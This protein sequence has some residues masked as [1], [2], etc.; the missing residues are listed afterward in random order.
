[1]DPF[2]LNGR[3]LDTDLLIFRSL[4]AIDSNTNLP[5]SSTYILG[6]DGLGGLNWQDIFT[7]ISSYSGLIGAPIPYLPSTIYSFS[8]QL[9]TLSTI[10]GNTF[11]TLSTQDAYQFSTLS[12]MIGRGGIPGSITSQELQSTVSDIYSTT[13][14][15]SS[16]NLISTVDG[17]I[18]GNLSFGALIIS[19]T[20]GLGTI[21]Y[22]STLSLG[23]TVSRLYTYIDSNITNLATTPGYVS[24]TQLFSTVANLGFASYISSTQLRSTV[25]SIYLT[26]G[27]QILSTIDHLGSK[28][29]ISSSQLLST[30]GGIYSNLTRN[31]NVDRA[32][33]L[34]VYNS[35]VT[36]SS[37]QNLAFLSSFYFSTM[38]YSGSNGDIIGNN[39]TNTADIVFT[40]AELNL[41][42]HSNFIVPSSKIIVDAYPLFT[43]K[44]VNMLTSPNATQIYPLSTL[45]SYGNNFVSTTDSTYITNTSY[46][47]GNQFTSGISNVFQSPVRVSFSGRNIG[48]TENQTGYYVDQYK[49][50]HILPSSLTSNLT[51]GI[52]DS[53]VGI[54]YGT[55]NS[56]FI[57]I[58]N[59]PIPS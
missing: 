43:F 14:Y 44:H 6:T 26:T 39:P 25:S 34:N 49:L 56:V 58:T 3:S 45:I 17:F 54:Y 52:Q 24:S 31:I 22:V 18:S 11:S 51:P 7:N 32:G 42:V 35:Q 27:Q 50:Y 9:L 21:G 28:G 10:T 1:M 5:V 8:S 23:S 30:T 2:A 15:I 41:N 4:F 13:K 57:T 37:L 19:T 40:S 16:G 36:I 59:L 29:Y 53:N 20:I 33:N 38:T 55:Q 12:T 47:V 48:V 46:L